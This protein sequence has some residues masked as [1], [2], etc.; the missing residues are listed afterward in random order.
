MRLAY[1]LAVEFSREGDE[2]LCPMEL[3][4]MFGLRDGRQ[5]RFVVCGEREVLH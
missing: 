5:G 4:I 2:G 1:G 3:G